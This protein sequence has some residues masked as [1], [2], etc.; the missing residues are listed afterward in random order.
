[1]A[2]P[3]KDLE[4]FRAQ[5]E[6]KIATGQTHAQI[7]SWL[8][9][10]GVQIGRVTLIKRCAAWQANRRSTTADDE[11]TLVAAIEA[12]FYTTQHNDDTIADNIIAQGIYT[13]AAQV[14]KIHLINRSRRR[15]LHE[16]QAEARSITF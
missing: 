9:T 3:R 12:A 4:E 10:Q 11:P 1:M 2:P 5:I 14:K 15:A 6:L 13:T 16:D 8:A 7:R